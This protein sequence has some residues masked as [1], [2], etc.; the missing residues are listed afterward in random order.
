MD[1]LILVGGKGTRLKEIFSDLPKPMVPVSGKPFLEWLL[2]SL[3]SKGILNVVLA[4]SYLSHVIEGYFKDGAPWGMKIAYSHETSPLGTGGAVR[5]ALNKMNTNNFLVLNGDSFC[6]WDF[7]L[8]KNFHAEKKASATLW[9]SQVGD[10]SRFGQVNLEKNG[11]ITGFQE[12]N[13][14]KASSLISA[15]IY[16]IQRKAIEA[17]PPQKE[18][19]IEKD[20]FTHLIGKKLYGIVGPGPF[21]DIGTPE[22]YALASQY[23]QNEFNKLTVP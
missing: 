9:L 20:F 2:I 4:T 3:K 15:G 14:K 13:H 18:F 8:M 21:L 1:A 7:H 17:F 19:S 22:S 16:I 6:P 11:E 10:G 5:L 12:K 23:L